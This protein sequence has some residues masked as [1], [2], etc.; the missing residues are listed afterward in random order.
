MAGLAAF[1]NC[2]GM[3]EFGISA[4]SSWARVTA[5]RMP[6]SALVSSSRAPSRASILRRSTLMLSGITR[7]SL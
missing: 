4:S 7:V 3:T 2:C 5:P 1:S 6:F